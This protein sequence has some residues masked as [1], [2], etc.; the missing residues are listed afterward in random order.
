MNALAT[1]TRAIPEEVIAMLRNYDNGLS[2]LQSG[3][4][5]TNE[6]TYQSMVFDVT[7]GRIF[8]SDGTRLPVSL[9]GKA[10]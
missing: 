2:H 7:G 3:H 6:G 8:V 4:S 1:R 10:K 5:P 9:S